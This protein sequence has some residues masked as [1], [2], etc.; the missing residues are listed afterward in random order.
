MRLTVLLLLSLGLSGCQLWQQRSL[1]YSYAG[2][3]Y[4]LLTRW[5]GAA[6]Q[7]LQQVHFQTDATQQEFLL[8]VQLEPEQILLVALSPLGHELGRVTL[9]AAGQ[10]QLQGQAPFSERAFALQLLAQMQWSVWPQ[11]A[12]EAQLDDLQLRQQQQ[13]RFVL[14]KTGNTVLLIDGAGVL[15]AGQVTEISQRQYRLRLTTLQQDFL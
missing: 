5:P 6:Q 2:G 9:T 1:Y 13:Q 11:A 12:V 4:Q 10:L 14:D 15:A 3:G 7:L 8:S